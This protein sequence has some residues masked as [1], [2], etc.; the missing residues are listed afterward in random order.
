MRDDGQIVQRR[1]E[2]A[3]V[4]MPRLAIALQVAPKGAAA[5]QQGVT[6]DPVGML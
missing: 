6:F 4:V 3:W 5:A 1:E 2:H